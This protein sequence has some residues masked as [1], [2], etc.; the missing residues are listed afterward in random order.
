MAIEDV[1]FYNLLG[2]EIS[3]EYLLNQMIGFYN[4]L[5]EAGETRVTD[6]NIGSE[7]R[8]LLE[9]ITIPLYIMMEEENNLT[10]IGFLET[11]YGV[12]LDMHG[13]NPFIRLPRD[14]GLEATGYV[15]FTIPEALGTDTIIPADTL[16]SNSSTGLEY[17][18]L[19]DTMLLAGETSVTASIECLTSGADGNCDIG[20][21]DTVSDIDTEIVGLSVTNENKINGGSD[22]EDD[23]EYRERLL[24]YVRRD[25][26]G[27]Q[28]HYLRLCDDIEG[29][30]D[31]TL[32]DDS[33][34]VYTK[35]VLVNTIVKPAT[36]SIL[37][38]VLERF[39]D[40]TNLVIGHSFDVDKPVYVT[41]PLTVDLTVSEEIDSDLVETLLADIFN[42]GDNMPVAGFEQEGFYI[43][44][45]VR[46]D[47]LTSNLA[48]LDGVLDVSVTVTGES[49]PLDS[50]SIA[51][52][53]VAVLGSVTVNQTVGD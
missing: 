12:W 28:P 34:E 16:V 6:F 2:E 46:G 53:E 15:T 42:G 5:L 27:S 30:H 32:I 21:I 50:F 36:D 20:D 18:V 17:S 24:N 41:L 14:T 39:T 19:N 43:G 45:D 51:S 47:V 44:D 22:Y 8:N 49:E 38:E 23:D 11:A 13:N 9:A 26:F 25:D 1:S 29:V 48:L 37:V 7:I 3:R 52:D 40:P 10:E 35:I 4:L 33:N 31:I